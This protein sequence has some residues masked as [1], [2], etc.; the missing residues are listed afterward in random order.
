MSGRL[1]LLIQ[2]WKWHC[3]SFKVSVLRGWQL[4]LPVPWHSCCEGRQPPWKSRTVLRL[5][6]CEEAHAATCGGE[7][8]GQSPAFTPSK[9]SR[10]MR[11]RRSLQLI[12]EPANIWLQLHGT[13]QVT[14]AQWT[15]RTKMFFQASSSG[16]LAT[17][18]QIT[19][20]KEQAWL[21]G[22]TDSAHSFFPGSKVLRKLGAPLQP[23]RSLGVY[24]AVLGGLQTKSG[25]APAQSW[26]PITSN[27]WAVQY[28]PSTSHFYW[29]EVTTA[30]QTGKARLYAFN[31]C[32][33][34][35]N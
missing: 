32:Y 33:F 20:T 25:N 13:P 5:P 35:A 18:Q 10:Q 16:L 9:P 8:P 34:A 27:C 1:W 7:M 14:A 31:I 19:G 15:H 29:L 2:L 22:T 24:W 11:E 21:M 28:M 12:P 26:N 30:V 23:L 6:C 17:Q 3:V 4:P